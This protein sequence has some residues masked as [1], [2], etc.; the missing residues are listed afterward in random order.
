MRW[1]S[2]LRRYGWNALS[3]LPSSASVTQLVPAEGGKVAAGA[4]FR[5]LPGVT[6]RFAV[7]VDGR[8]VIELRFGWAF[9]RPARFLRSSLPYA[10][11]LSF[12]PNIV[13]APPLSALWR[14]P[15]TS[16]PEA[17]LLRAPWEGNYFHFFDDVLGRLKLLD[18]AGVP[19]SVPA[20][21]GGEVFRR[22]YF[23]EAL[24][25]GVFGARP[26]VPQDGPIAVARLYLCKEAGGR[27][28][29]YQFFLD[30]MEQTASAGANRHIFLARSAARG[31]TL[32]NEAEIERLMGELGF[33]VIDTDA[34]SPA[35]QWDTFAGASVVV[36]AHSA[37][38]ANIMFRR[39]APLALLEILPPDGVQVG[40]NAVD[41]AKTDYEFLCEAFG[42]SYRSLTGMQVG[43][44]LHRQQDFA[45]DAGALR[46]A[47]RDVIAA[48]DGRAASLSR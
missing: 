27:A 7:R 28:D 12:H 1:R 26:V 22:P 33:E 23:Q 38:L 48:V 14:R 39:G 4:S 19:E 35:E 46:E 9:A 13:Q 43:E 20:I 15:T 3:L 6:T 16:L 29:A 30:R 44:L 34:L 24:R 11:W 17:V 40:Y 42:F 31:R 45:V 47:V 25:R 10:E 32:T 37:G 36:G 21:V 18:E 5:P 2:R 41:R 8:C